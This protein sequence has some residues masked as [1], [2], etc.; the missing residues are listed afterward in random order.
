ML[1]KKAIDFFVFSS[2]FIAV[3]A[4][5]MVY[6]TYHLYHLPL[7]YD[8]FFFVFFGTLC[9]YN[10]HWYLTTNV[11]SS[12]LKEQWAIA[13]KHIHLSFL[14]IGA[15]GAAYFLYK[16]RQYWF[17][18]LVSSFI[19]FLYSAPKVPYYPFIQLRKIAVAKTFF[20][21]LV[22]MHITTT[23]PLLLAGVHW[24]TEHL[25]FA[26]NRF[27]LIY[28]ICIL[29]DLRDREQDKLEGIKSLI[30]YLNENSI[31][32]LFWGC[33]LIFFITSVALYFSNFSITV[34]TAL[35]LPGIILAC[36][37]YPAKKSSSDYLY[38]FVLDGL[39]MFSALLLLIFQF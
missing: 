12:S 17:W 14:I 6:Q 33:I 36:M 2:L 28:P 27:F 25:L 8:F 19:T 5:S 24:T 39:M 20:L 18:L 13:H 7:F 21:S 16:L 23:L 31:D 29:F 37:Y 9:S 10:F 15:V 32:L 35:T 26:A 38:Y 11:K 22:W 3:C 4:V 34:I 30:T 1:V